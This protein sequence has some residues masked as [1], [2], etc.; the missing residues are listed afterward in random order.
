MTSTTGFQF[1][2]DDMFMDQ[3]FSR[4]DLYS[5]QQKQKSKV[6]SEEIAIKSKDNERWQWANGVNFQYQWLDS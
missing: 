2:K 5:L 1:L 4:L 6:L 3:D